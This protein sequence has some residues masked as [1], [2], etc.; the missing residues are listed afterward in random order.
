MQAKYQFSFNPETGI[1]LVR[2]RG[3]LVQEDIEKYLALRSEQRENARQRAGKLRMLVDARAAPVQSADTVGKVQ[4][5]WEE[6]I[7]SPLDR[8]AI[9]PSSAL[10]ALQARRT[11]QSEQVRIFNSLEEAEGWLS[12]P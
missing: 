7:R 5:D 11:I 8:I 2:L 9:V 10:H 6:A 1:L 3:Y 4:S 12:L